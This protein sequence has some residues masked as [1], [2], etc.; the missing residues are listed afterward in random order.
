MAIFDIDS[1]E[2]A[3][4]YVF[5][6]KMLLRKCFVHS[7]YG[8][9]HCE[10]NNEV[11][12][13]FGD[14]I[15]QFVVTEHLFSKASG[16]EGALTKHRADMVSK[17]P[18]L[19]AVIKLG[20]DNFVLLGRGLANDKTHDEKLYSSVYEALVAGIYIDGG[21]K[22]VKKFIKDTIIADFEQKA[23]TRAKQ[24]V[25]VDTKSAFQEYVQ[26]KHLGSI[27]YQTLCK[28]G[29]DHSPQFRVVALLNGGALAEGTGKSKK[30]AEADAAN[31][32][33]KK[34]EK[35]TK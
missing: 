33:L 7:S 26:K 2:S 10:E 14:A 18:L 1:V 5:K 21:I 11:L 19:N 6:D 25:K 9:E 34:L 24:Q 22:P 13:F 23:K 3:I 12:E 31:K 4:G 27:S 8:N 28:T 29:P 35:K 17:T 16:D 32:A 30:L 20:L 15:L